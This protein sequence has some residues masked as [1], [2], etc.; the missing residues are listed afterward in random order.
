MKL[1]SKSYKFKLI[2]KPSQE[3]TFRGWA[4]T[5]RVL[6][7]AA[8]EQRIMC[9]SQKKHSL[10]EYDQ[11]NEL[12]SI[13][14]TE[15]LEWFKEIPSQCLQQCLKDLQRAYQGFFKG[16]GFPKFKSRGKGDSFRFPQPAQ[17]SIRQL[18]KKLS[19]VKLPKIGEVRFRHSCKIEGR[20]RNATIIV[21]GED[22]YV[23]FNCEVETKIIQ[24]QG[25]SIGV[26]RG[27]VHTLV[28]SDRVNHQTYDLPEKIIDL[29]KRRSGIQ[30]GLR[31]KK[32]F[33]KN[34]F[35]LQK[36]ISKLS[37]KVARIR[38]DFHHK[39]TTKLSKN[40]GQ[41]CLEDLKVKNMSKS[42]SGTL[43][44]PG[45]NVA[46]KRGLN[47]SILRQGWY[48]FERLLA[49]KAEWRGVEVRYIDPKYTSQTCSSCGH[50]SKANR[51]SQSEFK[52]TNCGIK[53][54][55]DINAAVE[56][57]TRGQRGRACGDVGVTQI[58]EAGTSM[59]L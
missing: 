1:I 4:G 3:K 15:G 36:S 2:L 10:S 9:W 27:V 48:Q 33:S 57:L 42:A 51:I 8:L 34:W 16:G 5:C 41:I 6:Y 23:C 11:S 14:Q 54:N 31:H 21:N 58:C 43:E 30:K 24:A 52:C 32:K 13:K 46:Q 53:I 20:M 45:K 50:C 25:S 55:A 49:Y 17:F 39:I 38:L 59:A 44:F 47:R 29:E 40:H 7:N 22:W 26:D 28:V 12:K 19:A 35:K 37:S 56:I 18:S